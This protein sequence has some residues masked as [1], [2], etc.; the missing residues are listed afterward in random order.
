MTPGSLSISPFAQVISARR[1]S[2]SY[3]PVTGYKAVDLEYVIE[4]ED[5]ST[6][7]YTHTI[8]ERPIYI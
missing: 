1:V 6:S 8:N 7:T 5:G 3:D 2:V 4:A